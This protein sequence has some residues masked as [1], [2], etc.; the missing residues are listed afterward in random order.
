MSWF[1]K[2]LASILIYI[3]TV[4]VKNED[5]KRYAD[6][7]FNKAQKQLKDKAEESINEEKPTIIPSGTY[8]L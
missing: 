5:I 6:E 8:T 1:K 7:E 2:L 4:F 3:I